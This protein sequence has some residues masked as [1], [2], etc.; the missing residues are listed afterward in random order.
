MFPNVIRD[1]ANPILI[2]YND[3]DGNRYHREPNRNTLLRSVHA[4]RL[5]TPLKAS[6]SS[7]PGQCDLVDLTSRW[8]SQ[9]TFI[10]ESN[11][12]GKRTRAA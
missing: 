1:T 2:V 6:E 10:D 5:D 8:I 3:D 11:A 4:P 7:V 12:S 9:Q